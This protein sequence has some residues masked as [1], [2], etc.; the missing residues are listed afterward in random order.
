MFDII[1]DV[2]SDQTLDPIQV[3]ASVKEAVVATK[4]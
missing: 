4:T 1:T 3:P 2:W